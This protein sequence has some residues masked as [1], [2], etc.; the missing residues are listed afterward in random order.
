[1]LVY[2]F[3][4]VCLLSLQ[5][6]VGGVVEAPDVLVLFHELMPGDQVEPLLVQTYVFPK[7]LVLDFGAVLLVGADALV[8]QLGD[9]GLNG[10]VRHRHIVWI[11]E[12]L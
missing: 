2:N 9:L 1:M 6:L 11:R 10:R 12:E 7:L 4:N 5:L 8:Q 3:F